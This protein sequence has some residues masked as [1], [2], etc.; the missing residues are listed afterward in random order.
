[1]LMPVGLFLTSELKFRSP[2]PPIEALPTFSGL[3]K[4][5]ILIVATAFCVPWYHRA[6]YAKIIR[7]QCHN[8]QH[9]QEHMARLTGF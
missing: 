8:T 5:L 3:T 9:S 1:M 2:W 7:W 6:R 4:L